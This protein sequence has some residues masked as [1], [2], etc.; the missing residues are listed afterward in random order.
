LRGQRFC[1]RVRRRVSIQFVEGNTDRK[2]PDLFVYGRKRS[3]VKTIGIFYQRE[4]NGQLDHIEFEPEQTI[5][6]F[7]E[8]IRAKHNMGDASVLVFA[9]DDEEPLAGTLAVEA[10]AGPRGAKL[11]LHR[12]RRV[13]V[14]VHFADKTFEKA[15]APG[16][17]V[18]KVKR[19]AAEH[20]L[21]MSPE[22]ASEHMLQ[23]TGSIERPR[24]NSHV[25]ALASCPQCSV[26]F[27]LV[28]DQRVN[29][30][31]P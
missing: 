25:G 31:S 19:W 24:P 27:D 11:H 22:E 16:T 6:E 20:E 3:I 4:G 17:T 5:A 21:K 10:I 1:F 18:A 9:E 15:F 2:F 13:T 30:F 28:P 7:T 14:L 8:A 26:N 29:G 12:C 23:I